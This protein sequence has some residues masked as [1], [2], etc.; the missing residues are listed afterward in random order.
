MTNAQTVFVVNLFLG[1]TGI[2]WIIALAM[3]VSKPRSVVVQQVAAPAVVATGRRCPF[4]AEQ[5]QSGA[6]V[7]RHCGRDLPPPVSPDPAT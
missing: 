3:V 7:C 1:W 5:I 2:A 6:I 4:C